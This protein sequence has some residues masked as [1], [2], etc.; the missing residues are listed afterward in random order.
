MC[1]MKAVRSYATHR[2]V[3]RLLTRRFQYYCRERCRADPTY[4]EFDMFISECA[5]Y[6]RLKARGLCEE[7]VI[8]DFYG[9]IEDIDPLLWQPHLDQFLK[10]K[11]RP[12]AVLIEYVPGLQTID[13]ST[14]SEYRLAKFKIILTHIHEARVL[15]DDPMPRNMMVHEDSDRVLW[16]DFDR[17]QTFREDI[18]LTSREQ[19][20]FADESALVDEFA[21][22]LVLI[23]RGTLCETQPAN[24]R[25][26]G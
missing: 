10:D 5:A 26:G 2:T 9:V 13:L 19:K 21:S 8:P 12:R 4:R 7:Q 3:T 11:L 17:A 22:Y 14:Y 24:V 18:P 23:N 25:S 1:V 15:H 6:R 16:I 20:W